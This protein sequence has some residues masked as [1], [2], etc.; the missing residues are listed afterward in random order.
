MPK[1][2]FEEFRKLPDEQKL[3][4]YSSLS[5]HDRLLARISQPLGGETIAHTD[6]LTQEQIDVAK[7]M[8]K[9]ITERREKRKNS[10]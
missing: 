10:Q 1:I 2:T 8:R 6:V 4:E 9:E 7:E 5:D 3:I